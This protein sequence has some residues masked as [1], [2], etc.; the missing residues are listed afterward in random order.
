MLST[1]ASPGAAV[2]EILLL[3]DEDRYQTARR[4]AAEA[5]ARFPDHKRVRNAWAIF[6]NRGKARVSPQGP[7]PPTREEFEW[8][9]NPPN[10]GFSSCESR[11]EEWKGPWTLPTLTS[12]LLPFAV[13]LSKSTPGR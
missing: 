9:R 3:L 10:M 13:L 2:D 5:L 11:N 7:Q 4:M 8:L 12:L 1:D 6:D